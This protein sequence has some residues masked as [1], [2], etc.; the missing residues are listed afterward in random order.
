M[1]ALK[2]TRLNKS[3]SRGFK[4]VPV[5]KDL[6]FEIPEGQITAFIGANGAGKTTSLKCILGF[7]GYEGGSIEYFGQSGLDSATKKRIGFL[8][9]RPFFYDFLTGA[10]TLQFYAQ[11]S[12]LKERHEI[13]SRM[14][15]LLKK[16]DLEFAKDRALSTYSKGMLQK[17]GLAQALIHSPDLVI[18]DEPMS[19]L[20]PD[21]RFAISELIRDIAREGAA[22]F[23]S[24]H[25]L[26]DAEKLCDRLVLINGGQTRFEGAVK[27]LLQESGKSSLEEVFVTMNKLRLES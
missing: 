10:E 16:M 24:S 25:L 18:L 4:R 6:S 12:G 5:L 11:L 23:F 8:P 19:G 22:V 17:I 1:S 9:E 15:R 26:F 21:G 2:V 14:D 27:D 7:C 20:D 3:Y 13:R